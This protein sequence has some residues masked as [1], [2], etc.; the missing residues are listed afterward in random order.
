MKS[1]IKIL[2]LI[3]GVI[4]FTSCNSYGSK[5]VFNGT[6]VYYKTGV[7]KD[8]A[9]KLGNYLV[10]SEFADGNKKSVQLIKNKE[11]GAYVFRM[12]TN[13]EAQESDSYD[14]IFKLMA[15]Q[16]SDSVFNKEPV[17]FEVCDNLFNT[18]KTFKFSDG[19]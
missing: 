12:V 10:S 19:F 6:E 2:G 9:M 15:V 16:M 11:T 14:F 1:T 7:S 5:E 3:A 13:K 4:L 8:E 18:V 17:D